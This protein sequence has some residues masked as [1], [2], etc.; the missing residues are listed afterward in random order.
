MGFRI[1]D[2]NFIEP[3]EIRAEVE[4]IYLRVDKYYGSTSSGLD[5]NDIARK[6]QAGSHLRN[7]EIRFLL[8]NRDLIQEK[9]LYEKFVAV[10][11]VTFNQ[12]N[13]LYF[14]GSSLSILNPW[15]VIT[16]IP[17]LN[18][19]L[20]VRPEIPKILVENLNE[21]TRFTKRD[22]FV[23]YVAQKF[24]TISDFLQELDFLNVDS[25]LF[26]IV[27]V[28]S[29]SYGFFQNDLAVYLGNLF[30]SHGNAGFN[31][32]ERHLEKFMKENPAWSS[33]LGIKSSFLSTLLEIV[34]GLGK[35]P[36]DFGPKLKEVLNFS[37]LIQE[38]FS[39][40]RVGS[41]ERANFWEEISSRFSQILPR[42]FGKE[43]IGLALYLPKHVIVEFAP[44]GNA[45]YIYRRDVF[46]ENV[47]STNDWKKRDLAGD[48]SLDVSTYSGALGAISEGRFS[49]MRYWQDDMI[50]IVKRLE[51]A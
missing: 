10:T 50:K 30:K 39:L 21:L 34:T 23:V 6:L 13:F 5:F 2:I 4:K 18:D 40:L 28:S 32:I 3:R 35:S 19:A 45:A 25:P 38:A 24:S 12:E 14:F 11:K 33:S 43:L 1:R 22:E 42:K 9:G 46:E 41:Y 37:K 47:K 16:S 31:T 36:Q 7:A 27:L 49:H 48:K 44:T 29:G 51:N 15:S 20:V 8:H 17:V 26:R